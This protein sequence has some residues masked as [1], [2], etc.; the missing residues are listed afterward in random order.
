MHETCFP[1]FQSTKLKYFYQV[2]CNLQ[3]YL[4]VFVEKLSKI[5]GGSTSFMVSHG[6]HIVFKDIL[7]NRSS[8]VIYIWRKIRICLLSKP[9]LQNYQVLTVSPQDVDFHVYHFAALGWSLFFRAEEFN[10]QKNH[11]MAK[12][13]ITQL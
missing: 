7:E 6:Y 3:L 1:A 9:V 2:L 5:Q 12:H 4:H 10:T 11:A 8:I 13:T